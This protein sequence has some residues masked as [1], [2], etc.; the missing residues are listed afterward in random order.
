MLGFI[1]RAEPWLALV[2][3]L[4]FTTAQFFADLGMMS[5]CGLEGGYA[6]WLRENEMSATM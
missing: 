4:V 2:R 6:A 1:S 3:A 5:V